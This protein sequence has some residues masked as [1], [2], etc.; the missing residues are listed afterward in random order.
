MAAMTVL[1]FHAGEPGQ[2]HNK[3]TKCSR[4]AQ[5]WFHPEINFAGDGTRSQHDIQKT[6]D[7][8]HQRSEKRIFQQHIIAE[9]RDDQQ[10]GDDQTLR[11]N[12]LGSSHAGKHQQAS[13]RRCF[14]SRDAP[15]GNGT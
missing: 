5:L 2:P 13:Q 4:D 7:A 3:Q 1:R 14:L 6:T 10:T 12:G 9:D 8:H 11:A 15:T